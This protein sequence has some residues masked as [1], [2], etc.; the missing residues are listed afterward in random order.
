MTGRRLS[1]RSER[2]VNFV[3]FTTCPGIYVPFD[4]G[5][6]KNADLL[7]SGAV[8]RKKQLGYSWG[9]CRPSD[10]AECHAC[11]GTLAA[12]YS[13]P[14]SNRTQPGGLLSGGVPYRLF[15]EAAR[16]TTLF[17]FFS[18][19]ARLQGGHGNEYRKQ[20][21]WNLQHNT[22]P[23][24]RETLLPIFEASVTTGISR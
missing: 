6:E 17:F 3:S 11:C 10:P 14:A 13:I 5:Y 19:Q 4:V 9:K 1:A 23:S 12:A 20:C 16:S 15:G 2:L 18:P 22:E 21:P 8:G 7:R 24:P